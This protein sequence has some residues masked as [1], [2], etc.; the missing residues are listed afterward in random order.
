MRWAV[1]V[2]RGLYVGVIAVKMVLASR[3]LWM[4]LYKYVSSVDIGHGDTV[5]TRQR[6][7]LTNCHRN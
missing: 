1:V 3:R 2:A 5:D 6:V 7:T 4:V